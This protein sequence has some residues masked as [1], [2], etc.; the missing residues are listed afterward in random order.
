[1]AQPP[2]PLNCNRFT[3]SRLIIV[4]T[5]WGTVQIEPLIFALKFWQ[6]LKT[7]KITKRQRYQ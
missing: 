3:L 5:L 2:E 6:E 4:S 7:C 1:M